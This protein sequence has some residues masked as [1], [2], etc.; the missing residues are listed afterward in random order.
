MEEK[1]RKGDKKRGEEK[2]GRE[3]KERGKGRS[4]GQ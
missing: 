2:G 1:K 3:E 4:V